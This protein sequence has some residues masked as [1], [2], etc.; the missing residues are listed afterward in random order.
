VK[1]G[2][3]V[4]LGAEGSAL[5]CAHCG[6][7][8]PAYRSRFCCDGCEAVANFIAGAGLDDYYRLREAPARRPEAVDASFALYDEPSIRARFV[9]EADGVAEADLIV[10]GLACPACAWLVER[11]IGRVT[12]VESAN[13]NYST[14]RAHVRWDPA[15]TGASAVFEAVNRVG[16]KAWPF[17]EGRLALVQ[18]RERRALL[19]RFLVAALGM[20]QV[21]MYAYPAYVA[22]GAEMGAGVESLMRWSG[23]LLTLPVILYSAAPFFRGAWRDLRALRLGMDVP[24]VLGLGSA[25]AAS[26]YSTVV[27]RGAVYFDSVA[28]FVFLVTAGRYVEH[29]ALGKASRSLQRLAALAPA[30]AHRMNGSKPELVPAATLAAGDRVL[31]RGG[32]SVP[33]DGTCEGHA[34]L[35]ESLLTGESRA[36]RKEP[37]DA[38]IGG[39]INCGDAFIFRVTQAGSATVLS[40][41][42]R[43]MEAAIATRPRW[44]EMAERASGWFIGAI[45]AA[46]VAAGYAWMQV[47]ASRALWIAV[48]V[49]IVT[50]PCALSLATP[51]AMTVATGA[52]AR[53]N[54]VVTSAR[55]IEALASATDFVFDKTGTLTEGKPQVHETLRLGSIGTH[56]A[57]ALAASIGR[58]SRHPIDRAFAEAMSEMATPFAFNRKAHAGLG[59]EATVGGRQVRLGRADFVGS[60]VKARA[61]VSLIEAADTLVWLGSEDEW[62]AVFRMGDAVRPFAREAVQDLRQT[63]VQLHLL[64]GDNRHVAQRIA[65]QLD[66]TN[67]EARATPNQK[68]SYVKALQLRG[69]RVAAIGDGIND[70]PALAQADVSI[71][72]GGGAE[73]A[74]VRADAVLLSDSLGDLG[75][76]LRIARRTRRVIRQNLAWALGYNLI[77][78]PLAF[79]GM[80][81]PLV[82][83]I[84]MS[85]SSLVV[86]A[87]ALRAR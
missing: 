42:R 41:L 36:V 80:V 75:E 66:I 63:G 3:S 47:D 70:A 83:A 68:Q 46:A 29:I 44:V 26:A 37:G 67:V 82:A 38:V 7:P 8:I 35:S 20:M 13:V 59:V 87:N 69:A 40:C 60:L 84:G 33:A 52:L 78:L 11:S 58:D 64:T 72:M 73:L 6:L 79:A 48:S 81:T 5:A 2:A 28:M 15:R 43:M 55:A 27:G 54:V 12:G 61:P 74:Q 17:E 71:A 32:D 10:E 39:S 25:F 19:R 65:D 30:T 9:R 86:V 50:C 57:M 14:H 4:A 76:A 16:Y 85:A 56:A 1:R 21:M 23:L 34:T 31:V 62:I 24:I 45:I 18:E 49:L 53:R 77:V 22:T 51:I